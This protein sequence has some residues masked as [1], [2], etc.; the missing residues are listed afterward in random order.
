[1]SLIRLENIS[2]FYKSGQGVSRGIQ[3]V[4]LSLDLGEFVVIT[5]ESGG[6]K[7]T[8]LNVISGLDTYEE[9]EMFFDGVPSSG[10][11]NKDWEDYRANYVGF[12]F[13][14]YNIIES[15]T[16]YQNVMLALEVQNYPKKERKQRALDLITD[17]GL[18][19]RKNARAIK[20]SGGEKQRLS[21]ARA[22][23][24]DVD[25]LLCD[26]PTGNLDSETGKEIIELIHKISKG[27]LVIVV[28]HNVSQVEKY[29][30]KIITVFDGGIKEIKTKS[31]VS[32]KYELNKEIVDNKTSIW[33]I[34]LVAWRLLVQTPKRFIFVLL[35]QTIVTFVLIYMFSSAMYNIKNIQSLEPVSKDPHSIHISKVDRSNFTLA[36][37]DELKNNYNLNLYTNP[38]K[39][40]AIYA[41][42][43]STFGGVTY[44]IISSVKSLVDIHVNGRLPNN[45][46]EVVVTESYNVDIG[47]KLYIIHSEVSKPAIVTIVGTYSFNNNLSIIYMH[48]D[49]LQSNSDNT[50]LLLAQV[51]HPIA[52]SNLTKLLVNKYENYRIVYPYNI[53]SF[54]SIDTIVM[55]LSMFLWCFLILVFGSFLFSLIFTITRNTMSTKKKDIAIM[56]SIGYRRKDLGLITLFEQIYLLIFAVIISGLVLLYISYEDAGFY[57]AMK[58]FSILDYVLLLGLLLFLTVRLANRYNHRLFN[59]SIIENLVQVGEER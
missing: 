58:F 51:D 6:G 4:N 21:I 19:K 35:F 17:V 54:R 23:A 30:N 39:F 14:N 9:G 50:N 11:T 52:A 25:I 12:V 1:M 42:T 48:D 34:L 2:K 7:T 38:T 40:K 57:F 22:L 16:V 45:I 32:E 59:L 3:N 43:P 46:N 37:I 26:E 29:A 44:D 10:F 31:K 47:S 5:G 13:Q 49:L 24:K 18:L 41:T 20:L 8:L 27:K 15:L 33:S 55:Y 28:S 36:E 56:R 53:S